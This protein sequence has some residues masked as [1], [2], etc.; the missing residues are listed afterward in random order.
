MSYVWLPALMLS[1][2][3]QAA[4]TKGPAITGKN[5]LPS[6]KTR[7]RALRGFAIPVT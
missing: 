1:F 7:I 2:D 5:V 6:R 4:S 3:V